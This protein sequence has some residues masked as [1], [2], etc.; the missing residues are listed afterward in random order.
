MSSVMILLLLTLIV[1][2]LAGSEDEHYEDAQE[3]SDS[4]P[5]KR[6]LSSGSSSDSSESTVTQELKCGKVIQSRFSS[7]FLQAEIVNRASSTPLPDDDD[8]TLDPDL[9]TPKDPD[10]VDEPIS[11]VTD[12]D[13]QDYPLTQPTPENKIVSSSASQPTDLL[14]PFV[15]ESTCPLPVVGTRRVLR[16]GSQPQRKLSH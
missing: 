10:K 11:T 13:S 3:V 9:D 12:L 8:L 4:L 15:R 2:T 7:L 1:W 14:S 16:P 6:V 5:M